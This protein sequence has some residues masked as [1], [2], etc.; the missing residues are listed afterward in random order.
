MDTLFR[1]TLHLLF[2]PNAVAAVC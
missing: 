2:N 1:R